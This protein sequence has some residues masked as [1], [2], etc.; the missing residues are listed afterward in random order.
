M[1]L[2]I[3][4]YHRQLLPSLASL[5]R[6][7]AESSFY[8]SCSSFGD[9]IS[10]SQS[11]KAVA[12]SEV[13]FVQLYLS[14]N[15]RLRELFSLRA[16]VDL[17]TSFSSSSPVDGL[18]DVSPQLVLS[19]LD[20]IKLLSLREPFLHYQDSLDQ[21]FHAVVEMVCNSDL[22]ASVALTLQAI[23]ESRRWLYHD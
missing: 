1:A 8:E 22:Q 23:S 3:S 14:S 15:L 2:Q 4:G 17:Y 6:V 10:L 16:S 9:F 11:L 19:H 12:Q 20:Q 7:V 13:S 5:D 21:A 18:E